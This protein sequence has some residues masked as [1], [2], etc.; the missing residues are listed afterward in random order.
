MDD[1]GLEGVW[2]IS[3]YYP[4]I[5][6]EGL[7]HSRTRHDAQHTARQNTAHQLKTHLH[8]EGQHKQQQKTTVS[9]PDDDHIGR[10]M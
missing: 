8:I 1:I 6:L 7:K 4:G 9:S 10:N 3:S 2:L 5:S